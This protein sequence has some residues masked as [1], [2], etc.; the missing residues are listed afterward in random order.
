MGVGGWIARAH[1]G[2]RTEVGSVCIVVKVASGAG[3]VGR[4]EGGS[5]VV[6][7]E[8]TARRVEVGGEG[9]MSV[10]RFVFLCLFPLS[11]AEHALY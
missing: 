1:I 4:V 2:E 8:G 7:G 5:E 6:R 3:V 9:W 11:F 10:W